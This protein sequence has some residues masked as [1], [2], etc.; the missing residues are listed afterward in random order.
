MNSKGK[1]LVVD[2]DE[3]IRII[4]RRTFEKRGYNVDCAKDAK[5]ALKKIH[6]NRYD[7]ALVDIKLPD[8]NG[9][10]LLKQNWEI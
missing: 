2:D 6:K 7:T 3:N 9:I 10:E 4:L 8:I 5:E 1:I